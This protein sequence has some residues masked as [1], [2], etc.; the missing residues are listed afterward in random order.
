MAFGQTFI[1]LMVNW[2]SWAALWGLAVLALCVGVYL[3]GR[4]TRRAN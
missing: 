4:W 2:L 1:N 3:F